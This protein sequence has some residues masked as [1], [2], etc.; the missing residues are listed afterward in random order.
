ML[1]LYQDLYSQALQFPEA[2]LTLRQIHWTV[3]TSFL[4]MPV[5]LT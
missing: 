1:N 4:V 2:A 5:L 3:V